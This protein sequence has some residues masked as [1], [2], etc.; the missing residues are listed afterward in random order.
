MIR[1]GTILDTLPEIRNKVNIY[2][3]RGLSKFSD[4]FFRTKFS[5]ELFNKLT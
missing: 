3:S 1:I 5:G 4:E 2:F